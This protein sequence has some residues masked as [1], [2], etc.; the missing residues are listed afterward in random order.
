MSSNIIR[1]LTPTTL[2]AL[3]VE[4]EAVDRNWAED[5]FLDCVNRALVANV[6][7]EESEQHRQWVLANV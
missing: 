5:R 4:L 1:H 3:S 6:G 2:A 7:E